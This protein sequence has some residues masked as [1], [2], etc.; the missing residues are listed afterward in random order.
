MTKVRTVPE[1]SVARLPVYLGA[2][3]VLAERGDRT[4]SSE[5]LAELSGVSAAKLRKDLSY[6]GSNGI[7]GVGY[8]VSHLMDRIG[9]ALGLTSIW[10]TVV[11]GAG[12]LGQ[13]LAGYDGFRERGFKVVA[14]LDDDSQVIGTPVADLQVRPLSELQRI[15]GEEQVS[16][17]IIAVPAASSQEVCDALVAAGV[18]SVLSFAPT[19]LQ[20]PQGVTLRQ[21]DLSTELQILAFHADKEKL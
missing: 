9:E 5:Q 3:G 1:A 15:V 4:V 18:R 16:I 12:N 19:V 13:A 10:P 21:A 8:N 6:L 11:I 7:R 2:L 17:G 14:I 20:V